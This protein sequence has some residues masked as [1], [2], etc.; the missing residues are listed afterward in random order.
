[1]NAM[2]KKHDLIPNTVSLFHEGCFYEAYDDDAR[3]LSHIMG[4]RIKERRNHS[5]RCGFPEN[6]LEKIC[7][8]LEES[9]VS[10]V[11]IEREG[12][13]YERKFDVSEYNNALRCFDETRVEGYIRL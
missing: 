5:L 2:R 10:L 13:G 11:V 6:S 9:G 8:I 7:G 12:I 1:M 4:Y 3:V